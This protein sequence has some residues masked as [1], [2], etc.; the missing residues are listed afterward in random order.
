MNDYYYNGLL[1]ILKPHIL[2]EV[3]NQQVFQKNAIY[4]EDIF[5]KHLQYVTKIEESDYLKSV[6]ERCVE[7]GWLSRLN[8]V[9][10]KLPFL[11]SILEKGSIL[12]K[13]LLLRKCNAN[14]YVEAKKYGFYDTEL[15]KRILTIQ[16]LWRRRKNIFISKPLPELKYQGPFPGDYPADR[17]WGYRQVSYFVKWNRRHRYYI[18]RE[19]L[20]FDCRYSAYIDN[21]E[22]NYNEEKYGNIR[23]QQ[24]S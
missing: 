4:D 15:D 11:L 23:K 24:E 10:N 5:R 3:P 6:V 22:M 17:Y 12:D 20:G 8:L 14:C 13:H 19:D 7:K 9:I 2:E 21:V 18:L 1:L 16:R